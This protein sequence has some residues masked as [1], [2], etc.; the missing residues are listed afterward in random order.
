MTGWFP[1]GV[2]V[3]V[4]RRG[5]DKW[6]VFTVLS[7]HQISGCAFNLTGSAR[8]LKGGSSELSHQQDTVTRQAEL[9]TP[10]GADI[11]PDDCVV[12]L[13]GHTWSVTGHLSEAVNPFTGWHPGGIVALTEVT[14]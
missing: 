4:Q 6:G 9:L 10:P 11:L 5:E 2:T 3:T 1:F 8:G 13:D 14:G 12:D 7:E